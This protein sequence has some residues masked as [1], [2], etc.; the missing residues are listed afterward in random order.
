[1]TL[2]TFQDGKPVLRGGKVGTEQACCCGSAG[3]NCC[4]DDYFSY[5]EELFDFEGCLSQVRGQSLSLLAGPNSYQTFGVWLSYYGVT[6]KE[7]SPDRD[8]IDQ[9]RVYSR[10]TY[11]FGPGEVPCRGINEIHIYLPDC[12]NG[13]LVDI[14]SD[15]EGFL[16]DDEYA[17]GDPRYPW[18]PECYCPNGSLLPLPPLPSCNPL[19]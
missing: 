14:T 17:P 1:M 12:E 2:I 10:Q 8:C 16:F 9:A 6:K 7:G 19:P 4:E 18:L 11:A 5:W 15:Y 3:C 13:T